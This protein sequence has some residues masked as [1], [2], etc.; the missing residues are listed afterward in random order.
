VN[1][2][3]REKIV[4]GG[5][6]GPVSFRQVTINCSSWKGTHNDAART[7]AHSKNKPSNTHFIIT[8]CLGTLQRSQQSKTS[9]MI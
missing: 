2:E 1:A 9:I 3:G 4:V 5:V 8:Y 7:T 6:N